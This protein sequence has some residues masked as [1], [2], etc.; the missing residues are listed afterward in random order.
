MPNLVYERAHILTDIIRP[1]KHCPHSLPKRQMQ[2]SNSEKP[3][4]KPRE[5]CETLIL[6]FYFFHIVFVI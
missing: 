1:Q 5:S 6:D 4:G 2:K 3:G